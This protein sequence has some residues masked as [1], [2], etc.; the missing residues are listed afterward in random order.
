LSGVVTTA[1]DRAPPRT[2]PRL[3]VAS[4]CFGEHDI[5]AELRE[6]LALRETI[7]SLADALVTAP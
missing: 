3:P 7:E 1:E 5:P 2:A 4:A 6:R